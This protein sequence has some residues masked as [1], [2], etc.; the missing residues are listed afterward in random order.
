MSKLI[1]DI[2]SLI[3]DIISTS[4]RSFSYMHIHL[5]F[6]GGFDSVFACW[7]TT[8]S[9]HCIAGFVTHKF[10]TAK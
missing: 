9:W 8:L 4:S 2:M 10:Q 7:F 6:T 3:N 5:P 1:Q